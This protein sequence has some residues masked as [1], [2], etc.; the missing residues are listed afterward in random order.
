MSNQSSQ[1]GGFNLS[2]LYTQNTY[3][4]ITG[5]LD[6]LNKNNIVAYE[7]V[8]DGSFSSIVST[9][10][11]AND[12][13]FIIGFI[14]PDFNVNFIPYQSMLGQ[15][16]AASTQ[17]AVQIREPNAKTGKN[18]ILSDKEISKRAAYISGEV[19]KV[20]ENTWTDADF[21]AV[22]EKLNEYVPGMDPLDLY[23]AM[24]PES[25]FKPDATNWT[26]KTAGT[27]SAVGLIQFN[28][29]GPIQKK[30]DAGKPLASNQIMTY[31]EWEHI[32]EKP[33]VE[34]AE[35]IGKYFKV[36]KEGGYKLQD[37]W[38][39]YAAVNGGQYNAT[40]PDDQIIYAAGS[41]GAKGNKGYQNEDGDVTVG[42]VKDTVGSLYP[43]SGPGWELWKTKINEA[44]DRAKLKLT[45]P[46]VDTRVPGAESLG[47]VG[48]I[49]TKIGII[50]KPEDPFASYGRN[51]FV[52]NQRK[53]YTDAVVTELR[54][55]IQRVSEIPSLL[56][57]INPTSFNRTHQHSLDYAGGWR[58][59]I[60][61][62][63]L[64][65]PI[66]IQGSGVTSGQYVVNSLGNGGITN[67]NR[68]YS[69]SYANL[70]SLL[71]MYQNNG[72]IYSG[73]LYNASNKGVPVIGMSIFIYYDG[74]IYIGSFDSF[75][76]S[77]SAEKPFQLSYDFVF[78]VR[79]DVA[80]LDSVG[81]AST[82]GIP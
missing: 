36:K 63:W 24:A 29:G 15:K 16:I 46:F 38:N 10:R 60:V 9:N 30:E 76:I 34:Q 18:E 19:K 23:W 25:R 77:D 42:Q 48:G 35:Y 68:I 41:S 52:D 66:Q 28:P 58:G 1:A 22:V 31:G 47:I 64:E 12:R 78:T 20:L 79:Y 74:H 53:K 82:Q 81:E 11:H 5:L 69:L 37:P 4:N 3:F 33:I 72:W 49:M 13:P 40:S 14:P 57:Y 2:Q 67:A 26:S 27:F 59:N 73:E 32:R 51:I 50:D 71:M 44:K 80:L 21:D 17:R 8:D 56:L 54:Q 55:Q 62:M 61:S 43:R 6:N 65:Q 75:K 39:V 70:Q 7:P 45:E